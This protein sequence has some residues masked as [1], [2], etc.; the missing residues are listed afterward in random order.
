MN[1]FKRSTRSIVAGRRAKKSN[2]ATEAQATTPCLAAETEKPDKCNPSTTVQGRF[3]LWLLLTLSGA[4]LVLLL[5]MIVSMRKES[6]APTEQ[7]T[8]TVQTEPTV[9]TGPSEI[10]LPTE[11]TIPSEGPMVPEI[12]AG[13]TIISVQADSSLTSLAIPGD[14]VQ[15]FAAD[16]SVI[17]E[18]QY[19]QV[20]H[21]TDDGGLLLLVDQQQAV[22]IISQEINPRVVLVSH[23]DAAR[24]EDLL[25]LQTRI[26]HPQIALKLHSPAPLAPGKTVTLEYSASIDPLEATLPPIQWL[27]A[28]TD[29]A[30]VHNGIVEA[31]GVGQT[32]ITA[33]C[34]STEASCV[35]TVEIPLKEILLD[36]IET[37]LAVG[38][39]LKLTA[40][41]KPKDTTHF[42]VSWNISDPAVATITDKGVVTG[43]APGTVVVTASCGDISDQCTITIGYH[44]EIVK[45]DRESLSLSIGQTYKLIPTIYPRTDIIDP[46][47]FESSNKAIATVSADGTVTAV[48]AGTVTITFH[49][50]D[51]TAKCTVTVNPINPIP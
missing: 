14:V 49:C 29:V 35:I 41:P 40:T 12:G 44:A 9:S 46:I 23:D 10:T 33:I 37:T 30:K 43:V 4:F 16:G 5:V 50:G 21:S 32:T 20:F 39:T 6:P 26:N 47:S 48:A 8:P 36:Q 42:N 34:G 11:S 18:L 27:S 3:P 15:L 19:L 1:I 13:Q 31:V 24:A 45:L 2:D 17:E 28:D 38:K 22:A 51:A 7:T 25:E